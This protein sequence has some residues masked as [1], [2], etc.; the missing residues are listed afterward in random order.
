MKRTCILLPVAAALLASACQP[1]ISPRDEALVTR[2]AETPG[3]VLPEGRTYRVAREKSGMRILV[4]PA[5]SLAGLGH[6][7]VI[8]GA[9]IDGRIV[10]AGRLADSALRLDIDVG[11]LEVDRPQWR[12]EEGLEEE[13]PDSA[14]EGT[15]ENLLSADVLD[16]KRHPRILLAA[17]RVDTTRQTPEVPLAVTLRGTTRQVD[18]PIDLTLTEDRLRAAGEF[19]IRQSDFGIEP[20]SAAGGSLRVEDRLQIR[21]DI[22]AVAGD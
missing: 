10:H 8:G 7:H 3:D 22:I 20:F 2:P 21:F 5:G 9:V 15:R 16:A 12:R 11:A 14:V 13:V 1:V 19:T 4:Y 6:A 18:V 17:D